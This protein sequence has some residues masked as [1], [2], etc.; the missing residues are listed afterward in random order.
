MHDSAR[1]SEDLLA[2]LFTDEEF[3]ARFKQDPQ[4]VGR[5]L[6]LDE[7]ALAALEQT[8]WV[9]L[10]LAARSYSHK[11]ATYAARKRRW[12]PFG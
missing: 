7:A 11:R 4:G 10:D 8:D 3:R 9:G 12:W 2:R 5:E 6:G 1:A